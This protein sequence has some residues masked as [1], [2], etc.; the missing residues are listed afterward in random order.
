[1]TECQLLS[2]DRILGKD[3]VFILRE[4]LYAVLSREDSL[5]VVKDETL[6]ILGYGFTREHAVR[7]FQRHFE[8][9]WHEYAEA[10]DQTLTSD[11]KKLKNA[12]QAV[13]ARSEENLFHD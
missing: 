9:L 6:N 12:L 5:F 10:D 11:A 4:P 3:C 1:M 2:F 7:D 8:F 13:V